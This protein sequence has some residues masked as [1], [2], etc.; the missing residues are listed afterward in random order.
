MKKTLAFCLVAAL[1]LSL[2]G[3]GKSMMEREMDKAK[4]MVSGVFDSLNKYQN[5]Q[6][7]REK[8][9]K[10]AFENKQKKIKDAEFDVFDYNDESIATIKLK[11]F[12]VVG[13]RY[14]YD[15]DEREL[16]LTL[17]FTNKDDRDADFD[18]G[19]KAY[20]DGV[21]LNF[22]SGEFDKETYTTIKSGK[23]IEVVCTIKLRN[24][25]SDVEFEVGDETVYTLKIK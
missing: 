10:D 4:E 22:I 11:S 5:E 19:F 14:S 21:R 8:E 18:Y 9:R 23:T 7:D 24:D 13:G 16:V 25:T 17:D 3:C 6:Q 1:S 2:S 20:Q 12:V 15:A